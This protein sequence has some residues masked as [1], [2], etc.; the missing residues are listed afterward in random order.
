MGHFAYCTHTHTHTVTEMNG[1]SKI[2]D[3]SD[4]NGGLLIETFVICK[5]LHR[6]NDAFES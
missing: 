6:L 3:F 5:E 4:K 1:W 2:V